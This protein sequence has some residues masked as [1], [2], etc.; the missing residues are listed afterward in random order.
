MES[1]N[2]ENDYLRILILADS[3]ALPR[4][5]DAGNVGYSET[6]PV[7]L[8][9][10]LD[11]SLNGTCKPIVYEKAKRARTMPSVLNDWREEVLMK[12]PD[13]VIVHVGVV[14]CAPRVFT[15][16]ERKV[17]SR[18]RPSL[19][20]RMILR[21]VHNHRR[22]IIRLRGNV[23]YT[24]ASTFKKAAHSIVEMVPEARLRALFF[25]NIVSPSKAAESR[26]PG[27]TDNVKRY[28]HILA[29]I[30]DEKLVHLVDLDHIIHREEALGALLEDGMHLSPK[31]NAMLARE[32]S[33]RIR[34][35][36]GKDN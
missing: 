35:M 32:L 24:P 6:Y 14:D 13:I 20:R 3:L 25:V 22:F 5:A 33:T 17:I 12:R 21:F 7:L 31:G 29:E 27:F 10:L 1:T 16:F 34:G 26:S 8:Q 15:L 11:R 23:V 28:N 30:A 18:V 4:P 36:V 19:L 2:M 9:Q